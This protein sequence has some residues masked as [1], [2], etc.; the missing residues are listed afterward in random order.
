MNHKTAPVYPGSKNDL[1]KKKLILFI[2]SL[3]LFGVVYAIGSPFLKSSKFSA[4][5][6]M[7]PAWI[8]IFIVHNYIDKSMTR[9][10]E[11]KRRVWC[12]FWYAYKNELDHL[13]R[14]YDRLPDGEEKEELEYKILSM[15]NYWHKFDNLE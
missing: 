11:E 4:L 7:V 5:I 14:E 3:V 2:V 10:Y 13:K 9:D 12:D 8:L 1:D 6:I 15:E